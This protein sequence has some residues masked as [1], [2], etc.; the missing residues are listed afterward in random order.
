[1]LDR[2]VRSLSRPFLDRV[3][4]WLFRRGVPATAVTA[5]G[6]MFGVVACV[7]VGL[8]FWLLALVAWLL[9]R[10]M[11]GIDGAVARREGATDRGGYLDLMADFSIYSGFVVA[12]AV[13]MPTARLASVVLLS[14]YYLSGAALLA[15]SGLLDRAGCAG[16]DERS[17]RFLGGLAE[18]VET[19]IAYVLIIVVPSRVALIEWIFATMVLVTA[20]QRVVWASGALTASTPTEVSSARRT[21]A[22]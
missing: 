20:I 5:V 21:D 6:W 9:N 4:R 2:R 10:A 1:M 15:A 13:A 14:T 8:R 11:D 12:V 16:R 22:A 18:G 19:T 17:I 7:A 3:G